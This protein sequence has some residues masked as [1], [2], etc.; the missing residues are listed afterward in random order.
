[1]ASQPE[2]LQLVADS[3]LTGYLAGA[4]PLSAELGNTESMRSGCT[5][6]PHVWTTSLGTNH[7]IDP[8]LDMTILNASQKRFAKH[9]I[10][11]HELRCG[12]SGSINV[13]ESLGRGQDYLCALNFFQFHSHSFGGTDHG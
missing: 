4:C 11:E 7:L 3:R 8:T 9:W 1:M 12:I 2:L 6:R 13:E 5:M 10:T